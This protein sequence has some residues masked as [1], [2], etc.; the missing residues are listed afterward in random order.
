M[1]NSLGAAGMRHPVVAS[2]AWTVGAGLLLH[3]LATFLPVGWTP[4]LSVGF[5]VL[6]L[7]VW[8]LPACIVLG[9]VLGLLLRFAVRHLGSRPFLS[10]RNRILL[11]AGYGLLAGAG[12][13]LIFVRLWADEASVF[14]AVAGFC[15]GIGFVVL[16]LP[17]PRSTA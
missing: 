10:R 5:Y 9:L 3:L 11:V 2:I 13:F 16:T 17:R 15:F 1:D 12:F 14:A 4:P 7:V 6:F 8:T